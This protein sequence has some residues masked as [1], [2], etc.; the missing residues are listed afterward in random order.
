M[1]DVLFGQTGQGVLPVGG[2]FPAEGEG[3]LVGEQ[4]PGEAVVPQVALQ[5]KLVAQLHHPAELQ[6]NG[7]QDPG[8]GR[9][10][11]GLLKNTGKLAK[12]AVLFGPE[13]HQLADDVVQGD[14]LLRK[15]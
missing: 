11:A 4:E 7:I 2:I 6:R 10:S 14:Q 8:R 12:D 15:E 5:G 1:D 13:Q 3:I 9:L